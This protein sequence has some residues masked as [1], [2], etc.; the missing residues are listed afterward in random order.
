MEGHARTEAFKCTLDLR[1]PEALHGGVADRDR[2]VGRLRKDL[3]DVVDDQGR[4]D[5]HGKGRVHGGE[6]TVAEGPLVRRCN[7]QGNG[8][9][10]LRPIAQ[11]KSCGRGTDH[12]DQIGIAVFEETIQIGK[13]TA[14]T[15]AVAGSLGLQRVFVEIDWCG[16]LLSQLLAQPRR[17]RIPGPEIRAERM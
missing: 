4:I 5:S 6:L 2:N 17:N 7:E 14:F 10:K 15:G 9:K 3:Q 12:D 8:A 16:R 11:H 1:Q 13:K